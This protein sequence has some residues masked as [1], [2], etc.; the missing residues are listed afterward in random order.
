MLTF[1]PYPYDVNRILTVVIHTTKWGFSGI[2][3]FA[4]LKYVKCL[5]TPSELFDI[6]IIGVPFD[7]AV[8]YRPGMYS[9]PPPPHLL[10]PTRP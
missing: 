7:T 4:H 6:G 3:S 9:N 1:L 5:T 2:G 8:S 10:T